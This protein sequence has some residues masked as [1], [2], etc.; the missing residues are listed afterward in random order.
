MTT[1]RKNDSTNSNDNNDS[2]ENDMMEDTI[3][4]PEDEDGDGEGAYEGEEDM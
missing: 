1:N 3:E 2:N 4:Y